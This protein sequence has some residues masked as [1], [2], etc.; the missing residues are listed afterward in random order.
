MTDV[1]ELLKEAD[2]VL[3]DCFGGAPDNLGDLIRR[4]AVALRE[5][6]NYP[7]FPDGW[8]PIETHDGSAR[9]VLLLQVIPPVSGPR[10]YHH[11]YAGHPSGGGWWNAS[12]DEME[13]PSDAPT[14][15]Q[16]LPSPPQPPTSALE[17]EG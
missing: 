11:I 17:G 12:A 16:P 14:H 4:L 9:D 10:E 13:D 7:V 3:R 8:A 2:T 6:G 1:N 5:R 15:W